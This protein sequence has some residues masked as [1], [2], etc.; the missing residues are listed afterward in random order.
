MKLYCKVSISWSVAYT[1]T[2]AA[3]EKAAKEISYR[4]KYAKALTATEV[5]V[6]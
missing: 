5:S 3:L 4:R 1:K 2:F 6:T